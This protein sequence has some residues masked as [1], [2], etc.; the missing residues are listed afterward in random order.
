MARYATYAPEFIIRLAGDPLPPALRASVV[1]VSYED[2][3][4][5]ADRVD[6]TVA[7]PA[8]RWLDHPLLAVD[9]QFS[10]SIGYAPDPLEEVFVGEI[11][12][13]EPSFPS[14]GMPTIR[15]TAQDLL[16]RLTHGTKDR[17]FRVSI[18]SIGNFPLPDVAVASLVAATDLLIPEPD[19]IG[20]ALSALM[21]LA[22]FI[23]TPEAAQA[24]V[25]HQE[26]QT[27]FD[28]LTTL[29][30]ENGWEVFI[31]HTQSPKGRIL[32]FQF[33]FQQYT[34]S[35][36]LA[37]GSSLMEFTPRLTTVGDLFG[38]SARVWVESL[39]TEFV[40]VVSWNY[41]KAQFDLTVYPS[42][43]GDID[44]FLGPAAAGKVQSVKPT[45]Y[46]TAARAILS[47]LLPRLNNRLTGSGSTIGD[48]RIKAGKVVR[49]DGLGDQFSGLYRVTSAT[50]NID[51][52]GYRTNFQLRKEVW[53][54]SVPLPKAGRVV[55]LQGEFSA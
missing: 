36:T 11:T 29:A 23:Q 18:P 1:S 16:N 27:D 28:F 13:V 22:T 37:W 21:T 52:G 38:V 51:A 6:I 49:L 2:G 19:P 31:D 10:L 26:N 20:G 15:I 3:L 53:F 54:G 55:R 34:P 17:G 43:I 8:L 32:K 9:T 12:G 30:R 44:K 46:A 24:S 45:S 5:G 35:L 40:I 42:L 4:Q 25:R 41:D 33:L 50:H 47:E 7:N 48:P 14:S 39:Q